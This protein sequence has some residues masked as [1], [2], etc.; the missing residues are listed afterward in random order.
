M[1]KNVLFFASTLENLSWEK[2]EIFLICETLQELK[3]LCLDCRL[4]SPKA[5]QEYLNILEVI[6]T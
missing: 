5:L 4:S 3:C 2:N 6:H 1:K